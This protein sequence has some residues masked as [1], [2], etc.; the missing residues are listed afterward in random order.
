VV[1]VKNPLVLVGLPAITTTHTDFKNNVWDTGGFVEEE[2]EVIFVETLQ[3]FRVVL[4]GLRAT[5]K[6]P[7]GSLTR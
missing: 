4:G 7:S 2:Q 5:A 1:A 6:A 3:S